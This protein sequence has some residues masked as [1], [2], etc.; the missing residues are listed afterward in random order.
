MENEISAS[1]KSL[2]G[3]TVSQ[4]DRLPA[5]GNNQVYKV[6]CA[7]GGIYVAKV[8]HRAPS[9]ARDR[10]KTE[11]QALE[12][13]TGRHVQSIPRPILC[14]PAAGFAIYEFIE[15]AKIE[16]SDIKPKHLAEAAVFLIRL[17]ELS[18]E[19]V[20]AAIG[21]A[22]EASFSLSM[23]SQD[24]NARLEKFRSFQ[25][26]DSL[27]REMMA[28]IHSGILPAVEESADDAPIEK[29]FRTLSPSDFGFHNALLKSTG[30]LVF[31]DFEYF[32]WDDPVKM[33]ADFLLHPGMGLIEA[34]RMDFAKLIFPAF[35][36][37]PGFFDRFRAASPI[38]GLKWCLILLNEFFP[39]QFGRRRFAKSAE[40]D[41]D[42]ARG[43]QLKKA[44]QMLA[45]VR[46]ECEDF[47]YAGT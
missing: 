3:E 9:D 22:S 8:Y 46:K 37:D 25:P 44:R 6:T 21:A 1:L 26:K 14:S 12:F 4:I 30:E 11:Y 27:D 31:L 45:R 5:G 42:T 16:S 23:A 33:I 32:G 39:D 43:E 19:P 41:W 18:S 28:F 24:L 36:S 10:L 38:Y 7:S 15:G 34:Q 40:L 20:A 47:P 2:A 13:L 29:A 17:K 35:E